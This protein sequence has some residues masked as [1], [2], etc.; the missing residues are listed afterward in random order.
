MIVHTVR[1]FLSPELIL[2]QYEEYIFFTRTG[3]IIPY[4]AILIT[5]LS[6][7]GKINILL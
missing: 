6:L 4:R 5:G 7:V 3:K 1:Y 2:H